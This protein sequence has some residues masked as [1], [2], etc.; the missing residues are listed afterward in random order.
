MTAQVEVTAQA[1]GRLWVIAAVRCSPR[2]YGVVV[3]GE[4]VSKDAQSRASGARTATTL[5][6]ACTAS[7]EARAAAPRGG[8]LARRG[9]APRNGERVRPAR[10]AV[11]AGRQVPPGI[12]SRPG[13]A[14]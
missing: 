6:M 13:G 5:G 3:L 8:R 4:Q 7:S 12:G 1:G 9:L 11:V 10:P 14:V 2:A